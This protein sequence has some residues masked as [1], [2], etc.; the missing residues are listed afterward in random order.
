LGFHLR[1]DSNGDGQI[2][3]EV[4]RCPHRRFFALRNLP[5]IAI[6]V[7]RY[8]VISVAMLVGPLL[9]FDAYLILAPAMVGLAALWWYETDPRTVVGF[10]AFPLLLRIATILATVLAVFGRY[11]IAMSLTELQSTST[12]VVFWIRDLLLP[13]DASSDRRRLAIVLATFG[14]VGVFE[15]LL[16]I[17]AGLSAVVYHPP[18]YALIADVVIPAVA[19]LFLAAFAL[20]FYR[21]LR[22]RTEG[23][24]LLESAKQ[25]VAE[26]SR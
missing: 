18:A 26:P 14:A 23:I 2:S 5:A 21:D 11:A 1:R 25:L 12:Q 19:D 13:R 8:V 15:Y 7:A 22:L 16:T 17:I 20:Q 24:D 4:V 9:P 3:R 10:A 6:A